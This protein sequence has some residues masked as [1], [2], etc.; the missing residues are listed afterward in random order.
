MDELNFY[1]ERNIVFVGGHKCKTVIASIRY[2]TDGTPLVLI[3]EE[4]TAFNWAN[5]LS[6]K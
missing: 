1:G 6:I 2:L 5:I 3:S 4:G